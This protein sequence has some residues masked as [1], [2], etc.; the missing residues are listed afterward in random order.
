MI[1]FKGINIFMISKNY[2]SSRDV[3]KTFVVIFAGPTTLLGVSLILF[4][5]PTHVFAAMTATDQMNGTVEIDSDGSSPFIVCYDATYNIPD[6]NLHSSAQASA[7]VPF[8][9]ASGT[10]FQS[11]GNLIVN[12]VPGFYTCFGYYGVNMP[13]W[14]DT[15]LVWENADEWVEFYWDG[16]NVANSVPLASNITTDT[17]LYQRFKYLVSG[18]IEITSGDTLTIEPGARI[19]FDD[20]TSSSLTVSGTLNALG[21]ELLGKIRFSSS[22]TTPEEG[23]WGGIIVESGGVA[24]FDHVSISHAGGGTYDSGIYN[25][26][27]T[28]S[29]ENSHVIYSE[30]YGIKNSS[31]TTTIDNVDVGFNDYG[32]YKSGG[33]VTV[34]NGVIHDNTTSGVYNSTVSS[35]DAEDNYWGDATGPSGSGPGS[36]DSVSTYVD[37]DPWTE[38]IHYI[39]NEIYPEECENFNECTSVYDNQIEWKNVNIVSYTTELSSALST[40]DAEGSIDMVED[41]STPTLEFYQLSDGDLPWAG[42]WVAQESPDQVQLN[43]YYLSLITSNEIQN[44]I[45]HEI[46]HSLGLFHSYS[47]NIMYF[48]ITPQTSLGTQD[49]EDY[50]Y[51]W[52]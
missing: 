19:K 21:S 23:D 47:G 49:E 11:P 22:D 32:V 7:S 14:P 39:T 37:Y 28:V 36:G 46:G 3:L 33:T 15:E 41:N 9:M 26:G 8:L 34:N 45:T 2:R 29:V 1:K 16:S 48:L 13:P 4:L 38:E 44:A 12:G 10:G 25:N 5:L 27:G 52:P 18:N 24:N 35:V 51:L 17:T 20:T 42:Q 30:H 40:W 6:N 50:N 43:S 31:G